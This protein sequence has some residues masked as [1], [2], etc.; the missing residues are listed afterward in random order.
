MHG[1]IPHQTDNKCLGGGLDG[2]RKMIKY[3]SLS[4]AKLVTQ[5]VY[6]LND[7]PKCPKCHLALIGWEDTVVK[8]RNFP[9]NDLN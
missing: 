3:V 9:E 4:N 2:G 8:N 7:I 6:I 1:P 5:Y